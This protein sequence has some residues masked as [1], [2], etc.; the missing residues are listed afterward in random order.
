M[1]ANESPV[2]YELHSTVEMPLERVHEFFEDVDL[3]PEI[4]SIDITRRNNTL[5]ISAEPIDDAV[6]KYTPT[7]QLKAT[8]SEKRVPKEPIESPRP[9]NLQWRGRSGDGDEDDEP[10]T[11]LV[12]YAGFKGTLETVLQNTELR[13]AMFTVFR[14]L[15]THAERGTLTAITGEDGS[16]VA[17]RIVDGEERPASVEVVEK[18]SQDD[19][20]NGVNWRENEFIQ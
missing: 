14:E 13:H 20:G 3:P 5:I 16:L 7:A 19:D 6:S 2:V 17:T 4:A 15:A 9:A 1:S 8:V 12:E 18:A 11:E 10:V